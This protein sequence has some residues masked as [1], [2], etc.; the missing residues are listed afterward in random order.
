MELHLACI[1]AIEEEERIK[2]IAVGGTTAVAVF[3]LIL[4]IAGMMLTK[5]R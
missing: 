5:K 3:G 1:D 2:N 4:G